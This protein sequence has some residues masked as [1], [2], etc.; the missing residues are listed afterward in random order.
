MSVLN[1]AAATADTAIPESTGFT[2][3]VGVI[4]VLLSLPCWFIFIK[5]F[6][7][8][9]KT[10]MVG[11]KTYGH[12]GEWGTRIWT[13]IREI[14]G[15]TKMAKKPGVAVA[16]WFVM[17]GFLLGS[18]VWFEAYIQTFWP[19]GGWPI[20]RNLTA[21]HFIDELLGLGTT[22]GILTL[23]LVRQTNL[24]KERL[25]RFYGSNAGAAYFVEAVVL[26]EGLGMMF[27]KAAKLAT[28]G[29]HGHTGA[30]V[31][32]WANF[33]TGG[34]AQI[35]PA[36][37]VMVSIFALIKLLSGMVWLFVVGRNLTWGVAWHRFLA[38]ANI[39]LKRNADG[40][41]ALAGAKPMTSNGE[42]LNLEEADPEVD[43]MGTGV[44]TDHSWKAL[45]DFTS[46]TE[47]GRCQEQCPAW[48]TSKPLS[49]KLLV[50]QL[51]DHAYA[52]A[53]YLL[54]GETI[55]TAREGEGAGAALLT[56]PLVGDGDEGIIDQDVLWSCTN[57][58]ACVE[59]CPVD[60]EHIDHIVDMRRYQV[61][62]ESD[63]PTELAGLFKNLE[64]KGNPWGQNAS[65]RAD[66]INEVRKEGV[67]VPIWGEDV[68]SFD[69]TEYLFW[70][71]CA[72]AY[73]DNAKKTTKAVAEML[74]TAGVKYAVLSQAEGCTGDSARR[75]GNEFL[76]Q[77]L[78]EQNIEQLDEV[79][80]GVPPKQ[81][82]IV[83]TCAHCFNTFK[84]EYPELGGQ[85]EVV[86]HTQLLNKLVRA[87]RLQPVASGQGRQVTYHDPCFLGRHNKVFE[88]PR[89]LIGAS[90]ANLV[91]MPRNKNTGF[92]CGAGGARMWMEETIG[93][94]INVNRTEEAVGTGAEAIAIGCPFCKTMMNDGVNNVI[95]DD[96]KKPEVLDI[97]QMLRDSV[98]VDGE[99]P[100]AREPEWIEQPE[101]GWVDPKKAEEEERQRLEEE[102]AK[103][104]K[105]EA[106][107]KKKAEK[108]SAAGAGAAAA[109][110]AAGAAAKGGAPTPGGAPKPGGAK[111]GAPTPGGAK[112]GAPTPGGAPKPGGAKAGA[113]TP[114]GTKKGAPAPG[115]AP[116]PGGA[117][118][119]AP[120]P[121]GAKGGAPTPGGAKKGAPAPG[122]APK[123]GGAKAGAPVPGGAKKGAP[124]PGGAKAAKP[125]AQ[126]EPAAAETEAPAEAPKATKGAPIPGGARKGA[127]VPGGAKKAAPAAKPKAE[128]TAPAEDTAAEVAATESEQPAADQPAAEQPKTASGAPVPGGARKGAPIPGGARKAK[129]VA[130][131]PA[132]AA[133]ETEAQEAPAQP[134]AEQAPA[135]PEVTEQQ[136]AEDAASTEQATEAPAEETQA[137]SASA[138]NLPRNQHGVPLPGSARRK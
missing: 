106:A 39:L 21:W 89:E 132:P 119:G 34:I 20:L 11:Q 100:Q 94:R 43:S 83:V 90:G 4:G 97:A 23:I 57:C 46:C 91:E 95:E 104:K 8:M 22:L 124:V 67:V 33:A 38:F 87:N 13:M 98:K 65:T 52:S 62:V 88:A 92:C 58:G 116:K 12:T 27:V 96:E 138:K 31:W 30:E 18:L 17:V 105:A 26:I 40:Y 50:N 48:N 44:V 76:F 113:P 85:Y 99:L 77:M 51:R 81:R 2:V 61:L 86:H 112:K 56:K 120:V 69:D 135:Q 102:E 101:R 79:F 6:T 28:Y 10:I 75:A 130:S 41:N 68:E 137:P 14:V 55:E 29:D 121:G 71:G 49:P 45:L 103:R 3:A 63:F 37:E 127:P 32:N 123:P 35:L 126:A 115:G 133:E 54:A 82:K 19:A 72:G 78:A 122:G 7:H 53:P 84:N 73:D 47:C 108:A 66:W 109:G 117:K 134:V 5:G 15:H 128:E 16:H 131:T 110:A 74:Y 42:I 59:Q 136:S 111:G 9:V 114:G 70:V 36:S 80:D 125:A 107:E 93:Q 24:G 64:T 129:P 60:I 25:S 118:A 1:L